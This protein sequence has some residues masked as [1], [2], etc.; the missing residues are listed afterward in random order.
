MTTNNQTQAG[1]TT[2]NTTVSV[3]LRAD[4]KNWKDW[5]KQLTNYAANKGAFRVL[6][7]AACP[8]F[9][10]GDT[11]YDQ[12]DLLT[13]AL[14]AGMTQHQ[15]QLSTSKSSKYEGCTCP[16]LIKAALPLVIA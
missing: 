16:C 5:I 1:L 3:T 12:M 6:D 4:G 10:D 9:D 14:N 7:G 13:P 8:T 15:A 2:S 11:K